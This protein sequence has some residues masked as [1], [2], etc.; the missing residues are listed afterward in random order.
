MTKK[1]LSQ[2]LEMKFIDSTIHLLSLVKG[3]NTIWNTKSSMFWLNDLK[4]VKCKVNREVVMLC[5]IFVTLSH[6][7]RDI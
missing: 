1:E 2:T 7:L 5:L 4:V 6:Q 3:I